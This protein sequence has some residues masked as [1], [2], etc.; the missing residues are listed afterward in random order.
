MCILLAVALLCIG[1]PSCPSH[2]TSGYISLITNRA[3]S[4]KLPVSVRRV[5]WVR[6]HILIFVALLLASHSR[7][8]GSVFNLSGVDFRPCLFYINTNMLHHWKMIPLL[9]VRCPVRCTPAYCRQLNTLLG[10]M[11]T[12]YLC[13][14]SYTRARGCFSAPRSRSNQ[15][16]ARLAVG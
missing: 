3:V 1:C 5:C 4:R 8:R 2:S 11:N 15:V 7:P 13:N 14:T 10:P 16:N 9:R 12:V 6:I